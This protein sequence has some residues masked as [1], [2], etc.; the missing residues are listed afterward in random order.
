MPA[1]CRGSV[2][3]L[4]LGHKCVGLVVHVACVLQIGR[5]RFGGFR[6]ILLHEYCPGGGLSVSQIQ[7]K[8]LHHANI[9]H[10]LY[11]E[12][13]NVGHLLTS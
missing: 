13:H 5:S 8:Q 7:L 4:L 6:V 3:G 10:V 11:C 9:N 2:P 1:E 12:K